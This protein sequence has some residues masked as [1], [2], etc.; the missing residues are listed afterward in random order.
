[1][2]ACAVDDRALR[3]ATSE[4]E[5]MS[6]LGAGRRPRIEREGET[7]RGGKLWGDVKG[8]ERRRVGG[9]GFE[10]PGVCFVE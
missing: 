10:S 5:V 9:C 1:M 8:S 4:G 7:G 6:R 2:R 3:V